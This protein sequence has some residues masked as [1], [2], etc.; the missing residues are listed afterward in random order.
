M[1]YVVYILDN[2]ISTYGISV[3][4][5]HISTRYMCICTHI[6]VCYEVYG[7]RIYAYICVCVCTDALR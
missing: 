2:Y 4:Y 6:D 5:I 7:T 3:I 1:I